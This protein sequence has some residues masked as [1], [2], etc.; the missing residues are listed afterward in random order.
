L[1][2]TFAKHEFK[3][4][5]AKELFVICD[6]AQDYPEYVTNIETWQIE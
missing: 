5:Q 6:H 2:S 4:V 3:I 1:T